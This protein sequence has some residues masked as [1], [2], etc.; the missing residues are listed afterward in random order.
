MEISEDIRRDG[1]ALAEKYLRGEIQL[2]VEIVGAMWLALPRDSSVIAHGA[3]AVSQSDGV[4]REFKI[5]VV[6]EIDPSMD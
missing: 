2:P 3:I 4:R 5:G 1:A 6:K